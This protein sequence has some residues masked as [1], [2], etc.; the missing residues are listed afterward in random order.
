LILTAIQLA[1]EYTKSFDALLDAYS[2]IA[3]AL[4]RFDRYRAAFIDNPDFQKVLGVVYE[5]I[6]EFHR[7]A[8][9]FF[10]R[11]GE[12]HVILLPWF[13]DR[14]PA[15]KVIFDSLWKSFGNRFDA[16]LTDL[17][18]HRDLVDREAVSIDI[19]EAQ[20][21]RKQAQEELD[22]QEKRRRATELREV[23]AWLALKDQDQEDDL[24][25]I[26]TKC[27]PGTCDWILNHSKA[28]PW[29]NGE[30]R[31]SVL[32]LTGIP[33]SGKPISLHIT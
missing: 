23:T 6:L 12:A 8:Y 5:D 4:P 18:R 14:Q 2:Q 13:T 17:A 24:D 10:L 26:A 3:E 33:G 29:V 28:R 32:W 30:A 20:A 7:R 16:I 27:Q 15:W 22:R 31:K 9:K 1:S 19:V 21:T 25:R 11:R